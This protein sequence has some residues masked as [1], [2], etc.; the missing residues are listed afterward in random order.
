MVYCRY[1][2]VRRGV[3]VRFFARRA[4]TVRFAHARIVENLLIAR[5]DSR[6]YP[7][8]TRSTRVFGNR[9][10]L[11]V[12]HDRSRERLERTGDAVIDTRA[13]RTKFVYAAALTVY[14]NYYCYLPRLI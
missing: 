8:E 10:F 12:S 5:C 11:V 9:S 3:V 1:N 4:D 7:L 14:C 2:R 6:Q 13:V